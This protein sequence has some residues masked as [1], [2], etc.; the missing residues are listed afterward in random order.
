MEN[1]WELLNCGRE[2][3]CPACPDHGRECF[4]V[5]A[6]LCRGE[7]QGT[8]EAKIERCR[9]ECAFYKH[10]MSGGEDHLLWS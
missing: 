1:C 3:E 7:Q 2:T 6:T 5:T 8:Y 10:I 9:Q 4:A